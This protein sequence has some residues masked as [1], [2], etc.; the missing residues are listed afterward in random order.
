M[1]QLF[2]D[3]KKEPANS[4]GFDILGTFKDMPALPAKK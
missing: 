4:G 2:G 1:D 3:S